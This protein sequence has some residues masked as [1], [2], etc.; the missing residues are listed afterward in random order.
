VTSIK[1]NG[2]ALV[3]VAA[4]FIADTTQAQSRRLV[5][6]QGVRS[7]DATPVGHESARVI[8]PLVNNNAAPVWGIAIA[9]EGPFTQTND[10]TD[11]WLPNGAGCLAVVQFV[12]QRIGTVKGALQ[13][14]S[15][16]GVRQSIELSAEAVASSTTAREP[17]AVQ[18]SGNEEE[19]Y[20]LT[21]NTAHRF[22]DLI[23]GN[24]GAVANAK[25]VFT[26]TQSTP[27]KQRIASVVLSTGA[28]DAE[29]SGYLGQEARTALVH[30]HDMPWPMLYDADHQV[31]TL[32]E[33]LNEWCKA[34]NIGFWNAYRVQYYQ[35]P[36]VWY[37]VAA[38]ASTDY[39]D[40]LVEG[41]NSRNL[42]IASMAASGL[43]KLQVP[44]AIDILIEKGRHADGEA[45]TAIAQA[46]A[47][48][49]DPRAQTAADQLA[50]PKEAALI[51]AIRRQ[52]AEYGVQQLLQWK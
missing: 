26:L 52:A 37:L 36:R 42:M 33:A 28:S 1:R 49:S 48:Y 35:I 31:S 30:D 41:L 12:P 15:Y 23:G 50:S 40:L 47:Y 21:N 2:L 25:R 45:R 34:H 11:V 17:A 3:T 20:L 9:T 8:I 39:F 14:E 27:T 19:A 51:A 5:A 18:G 6:D 43:A 7:F 44:K 4:L 32:N 38:A 13:I 46:L 22:A 16:D 29:L 24:P 10:C